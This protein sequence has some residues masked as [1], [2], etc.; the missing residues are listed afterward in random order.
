MYVLEHN[1]NNII[2]YYGRLL[3][4][5]RITGPGGHMLNIV[6]GKWNNVFLVDY[7]MGGGGG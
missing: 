6:N 2:P 3:S 4:I 1:V 5:K 7:Y